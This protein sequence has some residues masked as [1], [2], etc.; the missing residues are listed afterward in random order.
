MISNAELLELLE[1]LSDMEADP[2]THSPVCYCD[3]CSHYKRAVRL[4]EKHG[5]LYQRLKSEVGR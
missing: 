3:C 5:K 2:T 1:L 4:A